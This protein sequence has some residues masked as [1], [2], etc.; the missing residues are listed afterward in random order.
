MKI[1]IVYDRKNLIE[2]LSVIKKMLPHF[3]KNKMYFYFPFDKHNLNEEDYIVAIIKEDEKNSALLKKIAELKKRVKII[4]KNLSEY[5][6]KNPEN[7]FEIFNEYVCYVTMYGCYGYYRTPNKIFVNLKDKDID[8]HSE[9]IVHEIAHIL[10]HKKI[11]G[12]PYEKKE[13]CVDEIVE[14]IIKNNLNG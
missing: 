2:E 9:T 7:V 8:F 6:E 3:K 10:L 4:E 12:Y 1:K 5:I 13:E 14:K 11:K